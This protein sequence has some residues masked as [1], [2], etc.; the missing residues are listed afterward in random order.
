MWCRSCTSGY[1]AR[2]G[3][4]DGCKLKIGFRDMRIERLDGYVVDE[5]GGGVEKR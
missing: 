5:N 4:N 1:Q 2:L 3:N